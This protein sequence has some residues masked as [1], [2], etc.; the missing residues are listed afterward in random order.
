MALM[1]FS[2]HREKAG[3]SSSMVERVAMI[4]TSGLVSLRILSASSALLTVMP[5]FPFPISSPTSFPITAGFISKAAAS[6]QPCL[7][8]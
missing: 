3:F 6:S 2:A 4:Q 7:M 1:P 5:V 8:T